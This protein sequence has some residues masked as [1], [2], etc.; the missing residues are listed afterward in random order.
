MGKKVTDDQHFHA[1]IKVRL[2]VSSPFGLSLS[3]EGKERRERARERLL[4]CSSRVDAWD[5]DIV[6]LEVINLIQLNR[7]PR[8]LVISRGCHLGNR[9]FRYRTFYRSGLDWWLVVLSL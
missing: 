3:L 6:T 4:F 1:C 7:G 8:Y 2:T 5:R 9:T